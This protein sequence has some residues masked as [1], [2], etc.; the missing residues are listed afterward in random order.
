MKKLLQRYFH[1]S[2]EGSVNMSRAIYW[3][4]A[5]NMIFIL[6]MLLIALFLQDGLAYLRGDSFSIAKYLYLIPI[7]LILR[8]V[9]ERILYDRVYTT[10]YTETAKKRIALSKRLAELPLSF[11]SGRDLADLSRTILVDMER[12]EHCFSHAVPQFVGAIISSVIIF[13]MVVAFNYKMA[14]AIFWPVPLA[15]LLIALFKSKKSRLDTKHHQDTI[16]VS[17]GMQELLDNVL[18]IRAYQRTKKS[19]SEFKSVLD[20]AECS[21]LRSEI[22]NP[23]I[24]AP[25]LSLFRLGIVSI[26]LVGFSEF[27]SG[28][29][30]LVQLLN[31][32]IV[33]VVVYEPLIGCTVFLLEFLYI[34]EP[35]RRNAELMSIE[36]MTGEKKQPRNYDYEVR[37]ARFAY[38]SEQETIRGV[39]F[40][41]KQG[42]VTALVGPSGCGKSTLA[43][44]MLRFYDLDSGEIRLGGERISDWDPEDLLKYS[45][46]V[47]QDVILFNNSVRENIRIGKKDASDEEVERAAKLAQAD[48]FIRKLP[49]GYN[50]MIGEAGSLLSGGERQRLSIARALLKDAPI[51]F[52]DESTASIDADSETKIQEAIAGLIADKTLILIAHRLRTVMNCDH[53]V[54]LDEGRVVEEGRPEELLAKNGAF[55]KLVDMQSMKRDSRL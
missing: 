33:S 15:L 7:I 24:L 54:V 20:A 55:K 12:L 37:D 30:N 35:L 25:I 36:T 18:P 29:L 38:S 50:T 51:I 21:Q 6:P 32:I 49:Q 31:F 53:I 10:T 47:F 17:N 3:S 9:T 5:R 41:A 2:D 45:S 16:R 39:S 23:I 4:A 52:L 22:L 26:L 40:T 11:F 19:L 8:Y 27:A 1:L 44:L 34:G 42:E 13:I 14:I 28:S 46:V 48:E 43:K